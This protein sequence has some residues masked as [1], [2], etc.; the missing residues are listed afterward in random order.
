MG[1]L[2][3]SVLPL[4]WDATERELSEILNRV[5]SIGA[6]W[7]QGPR[8]WRQETHVLDS[9][10]MSLAEIQAFSHF[11][12][13]FG[14]VE[15]LPHQGR[16]TP[17]AR[18]WDREGLHLFEIKSVWGALANR[19]NDIGTLPSGAWVFSEQAG[20]GVPYGGLA[21]RNWRIVKATLVRLLNDAT[22]QLAEYARRESLTEAILTPTLVVTRRGLFAEI[23]HSA[24][25]AARSWLLHHA[26]RVSDV[27]WVEGE[28]W[29]PLLSN[30]QH[31]RH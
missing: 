16:K 17:D 14:Q 8:R 4:D 5:P 3:D 22:K 23:M 6:H 26:S 24:Y 20:Q 10:Y 19:V 29:V 1:R 27:V 7:R 28:R 9:L 11:I 13:R 21:V 2:S 12:N 18:C 15:A 30:P 25:D 31:P